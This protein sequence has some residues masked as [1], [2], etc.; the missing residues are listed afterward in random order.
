MQRAVALR[1]YHHS[2]RVHALLTS[3]LPFL[4]GAPAPRLSAYEDSVLCSRFDTTFTAEQLQAVAAPDPAEV[5]RLHQICQRG[6]ER[7]WHEH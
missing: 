2:L 7:L 3:L 5:E 1:S 4:E 6:G